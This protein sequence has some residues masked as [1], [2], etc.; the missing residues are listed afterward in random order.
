MKMR[1]YL[2]IAVVAFVVVVTGSNLSAHMTIANETFGKAFSQHLEWAS[3][4]NLG[5]AFLFAPFGGSALICGF[6]NKSAKTR[7]IAAIFFASIAILGYFY[8]QGFQASEHAMLDKRWTAAA[9]SIGSLPFFIG[10]PLLM[11]LTIAAVIA[12]R[13]D[14]QAAV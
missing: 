4:T 3:D 8:F 13:V 12:A 14:R 5:V 1:L 7:T 6:A 10:I 9:L 11:A 2:L